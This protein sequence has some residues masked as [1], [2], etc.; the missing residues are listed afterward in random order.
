[1]THRPPRRPPRPPQSWS[2][3]S[4]LRWRLFAVAR[5]LAA[6]VAV[7]GFVL[8]VPALMVALG[9]DPLSARMPSPQRLRTLLTGP[10]DGTLL[11]GAA[12][13]VVWCTWA[14]ST[15]CV[16][17]QTI[18]SL[19]GRT[20]PV[21][22][23]VAGI[24]QPVSYLITWITAAV[25]VPAVST[26]ATAAHAAVHATAAPT[27][28]SDRA[29]ALDVPSGQQASDLPSTATPGPPGAAGLAAI[30]G[31]TN[32]DS[33]S[34]IPTAAAPAHG[35]RVPPTV[36]VGR[37]DTLW[38]IAEEHLGDGRRWTEIYRLNA[39]RP[40]TIGS[41]L[42]DPD[43][44][45]EG[46]TLFLPA[47]TVGGSSG[48]VDD[49]GT[50]RLPGRLVTVRPGDTL[51]ALAERYLGTAEAT[52]ALYRANTGRPQ[53]DGGQ[54]TDPDLLRPGWR[55]TLP[56][57][58]ADRKHPPARPPAPATPSQPT[59]T[60]T[61]STPNTSVPTPRTT[62]P[63]AAPSAAAPSPAAPS[64]AAPSPA[65]AS[66]PPA[67]WPPASPGSVPSSAD[68]TGT[69]PPQTTAPARTTGPAGGAAPS[70]TAPAPSTTPPT[71]SPTPGAQQTD[72]GAG[73]WIRLPSGSILGLGLAATIAGLL[74]LV[75]RRRRQHRIP[76][77]PSSPEPPRP[78]LPAAAEAVEAA[79][80][81]TRRQSQG[82]EDL[83]PEDPDLEDLDSEDLDPEDRE[84]LPAGGWQTG[85]WQAGGADLDTAQDLLSGE[86]GI[87][88]DA[89]AFLP[90]FAAGVD[91]S[92]P[93]ER[94]S[95]AGGAPAPSLLALVGPPSAAVLADAAW[96]GGVGL[97]GP[98]AAGA[99]RAV[100]ARL[101]TASG[102]MGGQ[103]LTTDAAVA[104]LLPAGA[105]EGFSVISGVTVFAT[106]AAALTAAEAE[107]L[108]R[109]RRLDEGGV[110]T[111]ADYRQIPDGEPVPAVL[112]LAHGPDTP[113]L[114]ARARAVL[115]LGRDRELGAVWLGDW[116]PETLTVTAASALIADAPGN[117]SS[118][119]SIPPLP[120]PAA[121]GQAENL[122]PADAA[123]LLAGLL[124]AVRDALDVL[125]PTNPVPDTDE[126]A[127]ANEP[128]VAGDGVEAITLSAAENPQD[129]DGTGEE[130]A[131]ESG[132]SAGGVLVDGV[133]S[134]GALV[135][136]A[137]L[138]V[139][140]F[141]R[142]RVTAVVGG[143]EV[144]GL[145]AK[146]RD[147]LALLAVH[148]DGLTAD[149]VV[150]ALWPDAAPGRASRR[151]SPMLALTRRVLR[152]TA[153]LEHPG[154]DGVH[155]NGADPAGSVDLIPLVDGRY[156]LHPVLIDTEHRRFTAALT[157]A[158]DA[159]RDGDETAHR[160]A[161]QA[162]G[163]LYR[164]EP[165][166]GVTYTW[167]EPVRETLR[168]QATDALAALAD[169]LTPAGDPGAG[170]ADK[171]PGSADPAEALAA[172]E[173]ALEVD[174]YNEEL[175]RRIMRVRAAA[176]RRDAVRRTLRLLEARLVDLDTD[177]DPATLALAADLMRS[178][179]TRQTSTGDSTRRG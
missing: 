166:D 1:M 158:A 149:Q 32:P 130:V 7:L 127:E 139:A 56:A 165:L 15:L 13:I 91:D 89:A 86:E 88:G 55:L 133:V 73:S 156:R 179:S 112:L 9:S 150:E 18:A 84:W 163:D 79:W 34:G 131:P 30:A 119:A 141:G 93:A 49:A 47:D 77:D 74:A 80:L 147:L 50:V 109:S 98:G 19:A 134:D 83:D 63:P 173:R 82:A 81:A 157:A 142:V 146:V 161:L 128:A 164:G 16:L 121:V 2:P 118:N 167:A 168:R 25:T 135:D 111:L 72:R 3:V 75:R 104:D 17:T 54:L 106:L 36:A 175:Y 51:S 57:P 105:A 140:V 23:G 43:T 137:V 44:I 12:Q 108:G 8:G 14:Y 136:G 22:R 123:G 21:L 154:Q 170:P 61:S 117:A 53:P 176:G 151:L 143:R 122:T 102:P 174:P 90:A 96:S 153:H 159:R 6:L 116:P 145:R 78:A 33:A 155:G 71:V 68:G 26:T 58:A 42:T 152:D 178:R 70:R 37:Y 162:V 124:P 103:L 31:W 69:A 11:V 39:D 27:P 171:I 110:D 29:A 87:P 177:P 62:A 169:S 132:R 67:S 10:D 144:T 107:L 160:V 99:A 45:V 85:G 172:L 125:D 101:L 60:T 52:S 40:Q 20:V 48:T 115:H 35:R 138:D 92:A 64:P 100:L 46:W 66:S 94:G 59:P 4:G 5:G 38:R 114:A 95:T 65:T 24:R 148:P 113:G 129:T 28:S 120:S 97:V 41:R 76:G 126:A